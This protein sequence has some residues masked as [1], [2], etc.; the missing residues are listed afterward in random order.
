MDLPFAATT[1]V[2]FFVHNKVSTVVYKTETTYLH[3]VFENTDL[4]NRPLDFFDFK[5]R[6]RILIVLWILSLEKW[7]FKSIS[8]AKLNP[9]ETELDAICYIRWLVSNLHEPD[10]FVFRELGDFLVCRVDTFLLAD[11]SRIA[12]SYFTWDFWVPF[13]YEL[14]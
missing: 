10:A 2:P 5:D 4:A 7:S 11:E 9:I 14:L 8:K 1:S 12:E 6:N 13:D 3:S